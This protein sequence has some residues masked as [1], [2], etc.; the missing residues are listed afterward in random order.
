MAH[1]T[2]L[3]LLMTVGFA[4]G[5]LGERVGIPR[6][7]SYVFVGALFSVEL[8]GGL[9]DFR[10][11]GWSSTLTDIALGAIAFLVGTEFETDWLRE[12]RGSILGGVL[13]Q[14]M[15]A[16]LVV[17]LGLWAAGLFLFEQVTFQTALVLGAI[18]TATAPAATIAV[19]E[20][21]GA[22]GPL[23]STLISLV[24]IDDMIAIVTVALVLTLAGGGSGESPWLTVLWEIGLAVAAGSL[25]GV[26]LGGF[27]I[28]VKSGDLRLPLILGFIFLTLG[29]ASRFHFSFLLACMLLGFVAKC[30]AHQHTRVFLV[31]MDH[32]REA[33]FLIFFTL[34]GVHF[35]FD[36]F[37]GSLG[38]I[39]A[40]IV[41]R[42][43]GKYS[44]A[45]AGTW[46]GDSPPEV[47][48]NVGLGL[49]PQAGVS[50]GLALTVVETAGFRQSGPLIMNTIIGSTILFELTAPI[51]AKFGLSRAGEI[52]EES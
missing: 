3:G 20:E 50:I 41:L 39:A 14:S 30:L 26:L 31:P 22:E 12:Q 8:L 18:A 9:L 17:S 5:R 19:I 42:M 33:I 15:G 10:F 51:A 40:Y 38:F 48:G 52:P 35:H 27:G 36:V 11:T 16:I 29:L 49:L 46:I 1:L 23:T 44:G 34:A 24:A 7:A 25:L 13:G 6:V 37:F 28:R 32:I 47:R 45:M 2:S 43:A 4:A 21:Y